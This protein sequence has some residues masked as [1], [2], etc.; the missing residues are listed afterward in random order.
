MGNKD[1][2]RQKIQLNK[3]KV[4]KYEKINKNVNRENV[5]KFSKW[6]SKIDKWTYIRKC[7]LI[8]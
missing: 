6:Y 7:V 4:K 5:K 3:F 2:M 8:S 1:K